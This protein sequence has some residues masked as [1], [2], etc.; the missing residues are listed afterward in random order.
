MFFYGF[1][2]GAALGGFTAMRRKGNLLDIM[3]YIAGYGIA[4]GILATFAGI[5]WIRMGWV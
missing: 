4:F 5:L 1:I 2:L 3:Q